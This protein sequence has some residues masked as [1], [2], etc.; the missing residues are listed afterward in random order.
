MKDVAAEKVNQAKDAVSEKAAEVKNAVK[1]E[2]E[3]K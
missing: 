1:S 3:G 2:M